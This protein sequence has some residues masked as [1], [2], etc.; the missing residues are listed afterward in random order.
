MVEEL[1]RSDSARMESCA[2][3]EQAHNT[4]RVFGGFHGK[5][6]KAREVSDEKGGLYTTLLSE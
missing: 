3:A 1:S 4:D 6:I 5:G 2:C